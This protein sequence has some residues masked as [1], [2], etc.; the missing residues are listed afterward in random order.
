M[1]WLEDLH[2]LMGTPSKKFRQRHIGGDAPD[3]EALR[4]CWQQIEGARKAVMSLF[5]EERRAHLFSEYLSD[6]EGPEELVEGLLGSLDDLFLWNDYIQ[7]WVELEDEG[8]LEA[9]HFCF[10]NSVSSEHLPN[11]LEKAVLAA[12]VQTVLSGDARL[13]KYRAE[14]REQLVAQ[15]RQLDQKL[16]VKAAEEVVRACNDRRPQTVVGPAGTIKREAEKKNRHMPVR[17]LLAQTVDVVTRLKPCFMMSPLSVSQYLPPNFKFDVVIF[18][19]AS[20]VRPSDAIN[21]VYR[22]NQLIVAGDE[23]QLPPTNFFQTGSSNDEEGYDEE[24]LDE[25]E[26]L[27]TQCRGAGYPQL[28]LRWHY[29]SRNEDLITFSNRRFYSPP[30]LVTFPSPREG[31]DDGGVQ[32]IRAQGVY[33]Q[34]TTRDNPEEARL[35]AQRVFH[36]LRRDPSLSIGAIAFSSAQESAIERAVMELLEENPD[37]EKHLHAEDRLE[38]F[39]VKNLESVQGDERDIIIFSVGYGPNEDGKMAMRFGP[40]NNEGG[41]KRLNVAITRAR[42]KVEV[43]ASFSPREHN[44]DGLKNRGARELMTYLR[45]AESGPAAL[46]VD[47]FEQSHETESPFEEAV[48]QLI[49]SWGYDVVPQVGTAGFRVD[50]GVRHPERPGE[51]ILGIECDGAMYHSSK[52]ARDRDR[53]RQQVLENLGWRIFR[54]WGGAWYRDRKVQEGRLKEALERAVREG[55]VSL[56]DRPAPELEV[57]QRDSVEVELSARPEWAEVYRVAGGYYTSVPTEPESAYEVDSAI[58][59]VL[60]VE[61]PITVDFLTRRIAGLFDTRKTKKLGRVV[62]QR[63]RGVLVDDTW[64]RQGETI[65]RRNAS[66][67]VRVPIPDYEETVR[68]LHEFP[69]E[70]VELALELLLKDATRA[71]SDELMNHLRTLFG[72]GRTGAKMRNIFEMALD[73]LEESGRILRGDGGE[74]RSPGHSS[75]SFEQAPTGQSNGKSSSA[76]QGEILVADSL[77]HGQVTLKVPFALRDKERALL[78]ALMKFGQLSSSDAAKIGGRRAEGAL[79]HLEEKFVRHCVFGL[80]SRKAGD[81]K[82]YEFQYDACV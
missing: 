43:V 55:P 15:F 31:G 58:R 25:F 73:S 50:L 72:F 79:A 46:A 18:D 44:A 54:I 70:E 16:I 71:T 77:I 53:L 12:Y 36:H 56:D 13:R 27:L 64:E 19:E 37:L 17:A 35:V 5:T 65:F 57:S 23:K 28:P 74:Y 33:R 38:G 32:F 76:G 3:S 39:F 1:D 81:G 51:Y 6:F 10:E 66:W 40:L 30:G 42:R 78:Q 9:L 22:G 49:R 69:P 59:E 45:Y 8:L 63:L 61:A 62:E 7:R 20:Q 26:S 47:H 82:L 67:T 11:V 41:W 68:G 48:C 80:R 75:E 21:C 2:K 24:Q 34:G 60:R 52:V 4:Y 14:D 29:R